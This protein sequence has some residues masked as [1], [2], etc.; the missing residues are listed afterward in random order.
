MKAKKNNNLKIITYL[1]MCILPIIFTTVLSIQ[2]IVFATDL[3]NTIDDASGS[4]LTLACT[5]VAGKFG[6]SI[7][8]ILLLLFLF[9]GEK[10]KPIFGKLC[11]SAF[12]AVILAN[13]YLVST[14]E[15]LIQS[16]YQWIIDLFTNGGG[17]SGPSKPS[18]SKW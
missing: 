3:V 12:V 16:T 10:K 9:S 14:G 6:K 5:I 4:F 17:S 1:I 18:K 8:F 13:V 15:S 7:T 2:N 11:L